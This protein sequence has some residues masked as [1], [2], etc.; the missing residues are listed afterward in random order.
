MSPPKSTGND[1]THSSQANSPRRLTKQSA[2]ESPTNDVQGTIL[3][4]ISGVIT[5]T[6]NL[7]Q[8][9]DSVLTQRQRFRKAGPFAV[10]SQSIPDSR[11]KYAG[12]WP[13]P[14][15]ESDPENHFNSGG[16]QTANGQK[17]VNLNFEMKSKSL[18]I[19]NFLLNCLQATASATNKEDK[20]CHR[21]SECGAELE[22][23]NDE[24]IGIM[25]II[26]NTFIHREPALAAPF[27]P[28]VLTTVS[29]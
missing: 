1:I 25:I 22:E 2:F 27:L 11:T 3:N 6:T 5:Q 21:C 28:E 7:N 13:P 20:I 4:S 15:Y 9:D 8:K 12:S 17:S 19:K 18:R 24:E 26:L 14:A 29:K 16:Q 10:D 23:Y